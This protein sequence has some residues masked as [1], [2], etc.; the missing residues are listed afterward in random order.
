MWV[1]D[2]HFGPNEGRVP[3][4]TLMN[5]P[6]L[7]L[8]KVFRPDQPFTVLGGYN[9]EVYVFRRLPASA[10][11]VNNKSILSELAAEDIAQNDFRTLADMDFESPVAGQDSLKLTQEAAHSGRSSFRLGSTDEYGPGAS[12]FFS[13]I[14]PAA[15]FPMRIEASVYIYT[16]Q[17]PLTNQVALVISCENAGKSY[18]YQTVNL[19]IA[20]PAGSWTKLTTWV[21]VQKSKSPNDNIKVYLWHLGKDELLVDDLKAEVIMKKT[22]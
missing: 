18:V 11:A 9:Y 6:Y 12:A 16:K 13:T 10:V 22:K 20:V 3:L 15:T 5:Q 21:I 1:W 8:L 14:N 4:E 2:A 17:K 7:K 19:G